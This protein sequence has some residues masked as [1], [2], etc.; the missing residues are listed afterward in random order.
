MK[1]SQQLAV[2]V[3][4][5]LVSACGGN[6][7]RD[8]DCEKNLRY[9]NRVEGKRVVAPEGLDQLSELAEM[10][11]PRADPDAPAMPGGICNDQ[12]PIVTPGN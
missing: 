5:G 7:T 2:L 11:I 6:D 4:A 12:P 8:V 10:S 3:L 9:Q 1:R